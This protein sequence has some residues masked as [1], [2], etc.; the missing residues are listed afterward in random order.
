MV[1]KGRHNPGR[2]VGETAGGSKLTNSDVMKIRESD[3]T[4]IMLS[5]L[6]S[7]SRQCIYNVIKRRT[8]SHI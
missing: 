1:S 4:V 5:E 3:D 2:P 8:W 7:V 6:Y